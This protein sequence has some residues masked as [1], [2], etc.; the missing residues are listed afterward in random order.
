MDFSAVIT[1]PYVAKTPAT[2]TVPGPVA[3]PRPR[4]RS[5]LGA[6]VRATLPRSRR[7]GS[8]SGRRA[9]RVTATR[10]G[11]LPARVHRR[12]AHDPR[13]G[14]RPGHRPARPDLGA[15]RLPARRHP[16]RPGRRAGLAHARDAY[17]PGPDP[18]RP[19][20]PADVRDLLRGAARDRPD[21][22]FPDRTEQQHRLWAITDPDR[23]GRRQRPRCDGAAPHRR[24]PPPLRRLPAAAAGAT[25]APPGTAG[26]RCSSTRTT[27]R[28]SS[29]RSTAC[30]PAYRSPTSATWPPGGPR[31]P[32]TCSRAAALDALGPH[33]LAVTDGRSWATLAPR[34]LRRPQRRRGAPRAIL[35]GLAA[36]TGRSPTTTR[37]RR[38]CARS[39]GTG[40]ARPDA[41]TGLRPGASHRRPRPAAAREGHVVPAQAQHRRAHALAATTNDAGR[42]HL[43]L[44]P[45]HGPAA[46]RGRTVAAPRRRPPPGHRPARSPPCDGCGR[47]T[48]CSPARPP[49]GRAARPRSGDDHPERPQRVPAGQRPHS[50]SWDSRPTSR[51]SL[52]VSGSEPGTASS[53]SDV[54]LRADMHLTSTRHGSVRHGHSARELRHRVENPEKDTGCGRSSG[55]SEAG[56]GP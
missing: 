9:A 38:P 25:R 1:P 37:W 21:V 44:H 43:D 33:S 2:R 48:P 53:W 23:D 51:T 12:W 26:W 18:A 46:G 54:L 35:P 24:R 50:G 7:P 5:G 42:R 3:G 30:C 49:A 28:S 27:P 4:R 56:K 52:T 29:A 10:A 40:S 22:E 14:R 15:G 45:R 20:G 17:E 41:G 13:P 34:P 6:S 16:P 32:A 55:L 11:A 19:P 36:G 47:S 39:G 31:D 8:A